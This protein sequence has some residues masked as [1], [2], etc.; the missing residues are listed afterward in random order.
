MRW[1]VVPL[2]VHDG[3]TNMALDEAIGESVAAG[4]APTIRLYRWKPSAVSIGYFQSLEDEVDL[5]ECDRIGVDYVRRRTGGGAVYHDFE[6]EITYSLLAPQDMYGPDIPASYGEICRY[7]IR[8]LDFLGLEAEFS[9][10]NDVLV[11]GRKISGSAQT[12]RGGILLQHGTLLHRVNPE[13]MFGLLRVGEEKMRDRFVRSVRSRVT[14]VVDQLGQLKMEEVYRA[15]L[16]GFTEGKVWEY[17]DITTV[18]LER[19]RV[20]ADERYRSRD[21]NFSR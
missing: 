12:R 20:L 18:E 6:G 8:S 15:M 17:G 10:V 5:E 19:A 4:S 9:P 14:S 11:N 13:V 21:W 2:Q 7:I 3:F 1:R 16:K